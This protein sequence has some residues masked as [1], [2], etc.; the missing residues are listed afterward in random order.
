MPHLAQGI[1][2]DA[3]TV[4]DPI[5]LFDVFAVASM[6]DDIRNGCRILGRATERQHVDEALM[7]F[8]KNYPWD[9]R[10]SERVKTT[11]AVALIWAATSMQ[12]IGKDYDV[13]DRKEDYWI[14]IIGYFVKYLTCKITSSMSWYRQTEGPNR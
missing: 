5:F 14:G 8:D 2:F 6:A 13:H 10:M 12:R 7:S 3:A 9:R 4:L 1:L 11:W